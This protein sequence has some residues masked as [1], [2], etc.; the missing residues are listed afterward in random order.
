MCYRFNQNE[1]QISKGR[2]KYGRKEKKRL[3]GIIRG[4]V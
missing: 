4:C 3:R 1:F 2:M